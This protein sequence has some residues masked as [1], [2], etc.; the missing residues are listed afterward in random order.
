[1]ETR[2]EKVKLQQLTSLDLINCMEKTLEELWELSKQ[3][4]DENFLMK[5]E[6]LSKE[7]IEFKNNLDNEQND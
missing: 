3:L 1:M 4:G 6:A 2:E 7:L 5:I